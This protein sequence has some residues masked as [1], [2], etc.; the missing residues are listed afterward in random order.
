MLHFAHIPFVVNRAFSATPTERLQQWWRERESLLAQT[1]NN[2]IQI[3]AKALGHRKKPVKQVVSSGAPRK[4]H[5][6]LS[7][8]KV[9]GRIIANLIRL[10]FWRGCSLLD[11]QHSCAWVLGRNRYLLWFAQFRK[12]LRKVYGVGKTIATIVLLGNL[13]WL[14]SALM[15]SGKR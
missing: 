3:K 9:D 12:E 11:D 7:W 15:S 14:S 1:L 2:F 5:K 4:F 10:L 8:F 6:Y 13:T